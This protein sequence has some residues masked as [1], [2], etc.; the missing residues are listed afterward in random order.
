M[1]D[2]PLVLVFR[3]GALGDT[4]VTADALLAL[5]ARFPEARVEL[6][7][8]REAGW[9]LEA[10]GLVDR[11]SP[12]D[13]PEVTSLFLPR[14]CVPRR[15]HDAVCVVLWLEDAETLAAA[16]RQAGAQ[17]VTWATPRPPAGEHVA[18]YLARTLAAIGVTAPARC[19]GAPGRWATQ[20]QEWDRAAAGRGP[21]L[22][23]PGS[24]SS[25]KNWPAENYV[26][27]VQQLARGGWEVSLLRGPAD[28]AAVAQVAQQLDAPIAIAAPPTLRELAGVLA[29]AG[30]YVGND[31]GVSHLSARLGVPSIVVFG[32]TDPATWAPRGASVVVLGGMGAW[33]DVPMVQHAVE[34]LAL[35]A[36]PPGQALQGE[37]APD[38]NEQDENRDAVDHGRLR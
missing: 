29:R 14:P 25:Q 36:R 12:F 1:V 21:A 22:L 5:R 6:V 20:A 28:T 31:S 15:W 34:Q 30:M 26:R 2:A 38:Q 4:I 32:P 37:R 10:T 3:P 16:F 18:A 11:V 9:L 13:A 19:P 7:G 23:H 27:L 24:G 8:N 33:P 35:L 17:L